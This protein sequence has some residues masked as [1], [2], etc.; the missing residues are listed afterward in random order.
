MRDKVGFVLEFQRKK[1]ELSIK[2]KMK[3]RSEEISH[4]ARPKQGYHSCQLLTEMLTSI[5]MH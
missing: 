3:L 5:L 2:G 1:N 4:I